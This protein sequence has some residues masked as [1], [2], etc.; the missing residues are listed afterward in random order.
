MR[1]FSRGAVT[2]IT[3]GAFLLSLG[4]S[5]KYLVYPKVT[6]VPKDQNTEQ[7]LADDHAN[8]FDADNVAPGSGPIQT[9]ARVIGDPALSKEASDEL[10]RDVGVYQKGQSI[11]NNDEPPPMD[12]LSQTIAIDRHTGEAVP[13]S[14]ATQNDEPMAFEG[15]IIKFPFNTQKKDYPYWDATLQKTMNMEYKGVEQL[16]GTKDSIEVY[17]YEGFFPET[18]FGTREVPRG[19]FGLEDTG[20]VEATRTYSNTRTLW[21]EP[22]TGVMMKIQ[23]AQQ[24]WLVWDEPG[25]EKVVAMDTVSAFTDE[26]VQKNIE[27]YKSKVAALKALRGPAPIVLGVLGLLSIVVGIGL[28]A[29]FGKNNPQAA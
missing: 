24:Q 25:A 11:D 17:R 15:Y 7:V 16:K 6:V 2:F 20:S 9:I 23:E 28:A 21:V 19:V 12:F 1:K 26:T 14:G 3:L 27:E 5:L 22:E 4:F 10:K 13:W 18:E 29:R 8:F